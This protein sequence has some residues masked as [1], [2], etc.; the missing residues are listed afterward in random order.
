MS[1]KRKLP[2]I[3]Y[4]SVW[5]DLKIVK[6]KI[7]SS[8]LERNVFPYKV[9]SLEPGVKICQNEESYNIADPSL[10]FIYPTRKKAL[11]SVLEKLHKEHL[12]SK[13]DLRIAEKIMKWRNKRIFEF[14]N[15]DKIHSLFFISRN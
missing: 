15:F 10:A 6:V 5:P 11:K 14:K 8:S 2:I 1:K 13:K 9:I 3:G 7:E 4:I 12:Q